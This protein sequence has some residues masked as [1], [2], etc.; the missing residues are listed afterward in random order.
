MSFVYIGLQNIE[1]LTNRK[2]TRYLPIRTAPRISTTDAMLQACLIDS[3]F[4]PTEVPKELATSLAPRPKANINA[5]MQP[6]TTIHTT[7][8]E[9]GSSMFEV[10]TLLHSQL[11]RQADK[12]KL[13]GHVF[14]TNATEPIVINI[15]GRYLCFSISPTKPSGTILQISY[16]D[17]A[18]VIQLFTK[19][20]QIQSIRSPPHRWPTTNPGLQ[21]C[22]TGTQRKYKRLETV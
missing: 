15:T 18:D 16:F 8:G 5:T 12:L 19:L 17:S 20:E 7:S 3:T 21:M 2:F 14:T 1:S 22:S 13:L 6:T 10:S 11:K 4:D 9:Y